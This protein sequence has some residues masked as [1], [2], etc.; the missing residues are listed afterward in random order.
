NNH[1]LIYIRQKDDN[2]VITVINL[3]NETVNTT[4]DFGDY[5]GEYIE[6]FSNEKTSLSTQY[7][8]DIAPFSFLVFTK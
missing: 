6:Y 7:S 2:T 5:A 3:S 8:I 1:V 4:C